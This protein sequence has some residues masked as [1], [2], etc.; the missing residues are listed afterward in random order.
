MSDTPTINS[1]TNYP[2]NSY[3]DQGNNSAG[4]IATY[5]VNS[6]VGRGVQLLGGKSL[7]ADST[8]QQILVG[9]TIILDGKAQKISIGDTITANGST[10]TIAIGS[11]IIANGSAQTISIGNNII[12]DGANDRITV[13][14]DN[15]VQVLMGNQRTFGEG[16]YV[17]RTGVDAITNTDPAQF[18]F[19]SNQNVFKVVASSTASLT[20]SSSINNN[21]TQTQTIAHNLGFTPAVLIYVNAVSVVGIQGGGGLTNLPVSYILPGIAT[22][23]PIITLQNRIDST[24]L[25][26]DLVCHLGTANN[27]SAYTWTYRYY[28]LQET[29]T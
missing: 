5:K 28:L 29:A 9:S 21:Q 6:G 26:L 27:F 7:I 11:T 13:E 4:L 23:Y 16:F 8:K 12:A 14:R 18:I 17:T 22:S 20:G 19:N 3:Q 2:K 25:Y 1:N 24:N 10:Q 15:I